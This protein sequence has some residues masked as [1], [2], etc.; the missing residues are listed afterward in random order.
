MTMDKTITVF[1]AVS[2]RGQGNVYMEKPER[3]DHFKLW[4]GHI[5]GCVHTFISMMEAD[6]LE[7][8]TIGWKD[9]PVEIT[10]TVSV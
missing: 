2:G 9:E 4:E 3:N 10:V 1:F 8:P 5:D 7:L 6:G